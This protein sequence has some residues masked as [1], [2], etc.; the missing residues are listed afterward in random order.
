M[1]K[2]TFTEGDQVIIPSH[3]ELGIFEVVSYALSLDHDAKAI[4][5]CVI[6]AIE[7]QRL[8]GELIGEVAIDLNMI[9]HV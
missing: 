9:A 8:E 7:G 5:V 3:K 6:K 1:K 2:R 4:L